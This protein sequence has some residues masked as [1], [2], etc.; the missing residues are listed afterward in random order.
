MASVP[1]ALAA[2]IADWCP[3]PAIH[4]RVASIRRAAHVIDE[5]GREWVDFVSG[6][7][8]NLLGYDHPAVLGAVRRQLECGV[9]TGIPTRVGFEVM[10]LLR[11]LVPCAEEVA[12]GKNGSD[13]TAGAVRLARALTG[14]DKVLVRGYHGFHDWY[15]ASDPV[16][17]GIPAALR[18][19]V[20]AVP[21]NDLEALAGL[22]GGDPGG[23]A[24][25]ILDPAAEPLPTTEYLA[26][27]AELAHRH[28]ALVI[29]DEVV[30]GFRL[31]AGGAQ[32]HY[33]VT[34]DLA[35]VSKAMANGFPLSALLG[36]RRLMQELPATRFGMTFSQEVA[37]L[38][39]CRATLTEVRDGGVCRRLSQTAE[40]LRRELARL[41]EERGVA[42]ELAG[43]P[44]LTRL[45]FREQGGLS[46][47]ELRWLVL[48]ELAR[49]DVATAGVLI[50]SAGHTAADVDRLVAAFE[51]GLEVVG[52]ALE[53]GSVEGLLEPELLAGVRAHG[54]AATPDAPAPRPAAGLREEPAEASA[55][56]APTPPA[57]AD[58][59]G[60][61][62]LGRFLRDRVRELRQILRARRR[63]PPEATDEEIQSRLP[64][65]FDW[66]SYLE[67][68]PDLRA[69]GIDAEPDAARHFV[70]FGAAEG[71]TGSPTM[72]DEEVL[73]ALPDDFDA[74]A[75]LR[76]Y[77]DLAEAGVVTEIDAARHWLA[78]G[79]AEGRWATQASYPTRRAM[80]CPS[81]GT[82]FLRSWGALTCWEDAGCLTELQPFDEGVDYGAGV[83]LGEPYNRI[84][85]SL[86][87]NRL[88][89]P[90]VCNRCIGL[91]THHEH[92]SEHVDRRVMDVFHVEPS[93]RCS[94]DCPGCI[95][96]DQR[97]HAPKPLTLPREWLEKILTD[98]AGSGVTVKRLIY[99]GHGEP[100]TH[101]DLAG[102]CRLA[103][104]YYPKS[105]LTVGTNA[106]GRFTAELAEA[107]IDEMVCS[108]DGVDQA[109]YEVYRRGGRFDLAYRFLREVAAAGG[110]G[111]Q[112]IRVVWKYILFEHN[113]S[114]EQ[115]IRAQEMARDA[116]VDELHFVFTRNGPAS[117]RV[118]RRSQV[119][120]IESGVEVTFGYHGPDLTDMERRLAAAE[121]QLARGD[122][123]AAKPLLESIALNLARFFPRADDLDEHYTI[124]LRSLLRL[125]ED[126][127]GDEGKAILSRVERLRPQAATSSP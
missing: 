9:G 90:D 50:V 63:P 23:V 71:R 14:R 84:R 56:P 100:L 33:G 42:V 124:L 51:E 101:P 72:T 3:H 98:L 97:R 5:D 93:Y 115:L 17:Q 22:L 45:R 25:V 60:R 59:L 29:Y 94:I 69:I 70:L 74:R 103:K 37:S 8:S 41:A 11:E 83:Y 88:P 119:P 91:R 4:P 1:G 85:R 7:G 58:P 6:W 127:P 28:G 46:E 10:D 82:M 108:I 35:C 117:R 49:R 76:R 106:N 89:S 112:P 19:T 2:P 43:H 18:A 95:P 15:L 67:R 26:G 24:A 36:P 121:G 73:A 66:R 92:S 55:P 120:V 20:G 78:S 30:T 27:L 105:Y 107:G 39:A 114:N 47:R 87:E 79:K 77:A 31:A 32:E 16:Y 13:A 80:M 109:S 53:R 104:S 68:Y 110:D 12:F 118:V 122:D 116:G 96:R 64:T 57:P 52:E 125:A 62:H 102:L 40:R 54:A 81:V 99:Q 34:P 75:Y 123:G 48:Q 111:S 113:D 126:L 61:P 44:P 86:Y 21:G 65:D 38:A